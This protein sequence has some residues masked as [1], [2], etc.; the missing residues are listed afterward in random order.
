MGGV[1]NFAIV[2]LALHEAGYKSVGIRIDSGNL[3]QQSFEIKAYFDKLAKQYNKEAFTGLAIVASNDIDEEQL[4]KLN[5]SEVT[6]YGVGTRLVTCK[7]N[8]ALG[9]VFKLVELD[10]V[11]RIKLSSDRFKTTIPA[12][13]QCYRMFGKNDE[14][15]CDVLTYADAKAPVEG[16]NLKIKDFFNPHADFTVSPSRVEKLLHPV[17]AKGKVLVKL[18]KIKQLRERAQ[19]NI[20]KLPPSRTRRVSPVPYRVLLSEKLYQDVHKM[21]DAATPN[22]R[23][24]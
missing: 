23:L 14:M 7:G 24:E 3:V 17:W 15:L 13:K 1:V 22:V 2:A 19:N 9:G 16:R 20:W 6:G 4:E 11:P 21:M 8:P 5:K 10:R 18:P 12:R